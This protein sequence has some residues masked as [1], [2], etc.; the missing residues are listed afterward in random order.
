MRPKLLFIILLFFISSPDGISQ[1]GGCTDIEALN[2]SPSAVINDGSCIY[3]PASLSPHK[4]IVLPEILS[5]SSGLTLWNSQLWSHNDND[6]NNIYAIDT[7]SLSS[8]S[9]FE[10][11]GTVNNDWEEITSDEK[12]IYIGDFGNNVDG[13]RKD[14]RILK[15]DKNSI[16]R[17]EPEIDTIAFSWSDQDEYDPSGFFNTD[18]DCEAFI[19]LGDSLYLF[20][21]QWL[22]RKTGIYSLPGEPGSH[23][24]RLKMVHDSE[25]L[26]TGATCLQSENIVVLCGYDGTGYPFLILMY[27]FQGYDFT[28]GNIRK[29]MIDLPYHQTEGISTDDG[30]KYYISNERTSTPYGFVIQQKVH[31]LDLKPFLG[32]YLNGNSQNTGHHYMADELQVYPNPVSGI[33]TII[34]GTTAPLSYKIIT[35]NGVVVRSGSIE[36]GSA[37]IDITDLSSGSYQIVTEGEQVR[38]VRIIK[39]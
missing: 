10:L 17:D 31:V 21:K 38:T 7:V 6:D 23:I 13:N 19:A 9:S 22:S 35:W 16:L 12:Y 14:L 28:G 2:F 24:A 5:E 8:I 3:Y 1:T 37:T 32:L 18:F 25:G 15:I 20:T 27:D 39:I 26:I 11:T 29:I 4:S 30:L 36:G 34:T 33:L